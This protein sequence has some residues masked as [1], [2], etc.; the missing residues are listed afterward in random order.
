MA[1]LGLYPMF[2]FKD[3]KEIEAKVLATPEKV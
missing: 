2:S 1:L 3:K